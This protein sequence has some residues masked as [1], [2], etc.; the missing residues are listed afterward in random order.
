MLNPSY[1]KRQARHVK[2]NC[3]KSSHKSLLLEIISQLVKILLTCVKQPHVNWANIVYF[4]HDVV[5]SPNVISCLVWCIHFFGMYCIVLVFQYNTNT[6]SHFV[7]ED[8][9]NTMYMP[10]Q[11]M[12]C[13]CC[14]VDGTQCSALQTIGLCLDQRI[15]QLIRLYSFITNWPSYI[16]MYESLIQFSPASSLLYYRK[17]FRLLFV[18]SMKK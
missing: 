18:W 3:I 15:S 5:P 1:K 13:I 14:T 2:S 12:Y 16:G 17:T 11:H 10:I 6:P 4:L 9:Y 8:E 7:F